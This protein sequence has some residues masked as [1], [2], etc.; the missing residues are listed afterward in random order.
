MRK[1][2]GKKALIMC[3]GPFLKE[4]CSGPSKKPYIRRHCALSTTLL[5][6]ARGQG[7]KDVFNVGVTANQ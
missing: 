2:T 6:K 7:R 3:K 4:G 5:C 1:K